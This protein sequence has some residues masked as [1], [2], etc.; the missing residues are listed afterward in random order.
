MR[1]IPKRVENAENI[2]RDAFGLPDITGR[3]DQVF[4]KGTWLIHANPQRVFG[5]MGSSGANIT[6][7]TGH[8]MTFTGHQLADGVTGD[9]AAQ[10]RDFATEFMSQ[11]ASGWEPSLAP[12]HP[13]DRYGHPCHRS[14]CGE[15]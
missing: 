4:S 11:Y 12:S 8:H 7:A 14:R 10:S 1:G 2:F 6:T 9:I 15:F 3:Q 5:Q 13:T